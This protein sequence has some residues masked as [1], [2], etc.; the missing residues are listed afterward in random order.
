MLRNIFHKNARQELAAI[1]LI[2]VLVVATL[3]GLFY[4]LG[5]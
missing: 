1:A 2:S 5:V 3:A 4:L